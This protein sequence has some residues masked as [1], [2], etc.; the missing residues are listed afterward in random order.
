MHHPGCFLQTLPSCLFPL[1]I[2][3]AW[4][5]PDLKIWCLSASYVNKDV[6]LDLA[7][8]DDDS[9]YPDPKQMEEPGEILK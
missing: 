8:G 9:F 3:K 5:A 2:P 6:G 4:L 1:V 7:G